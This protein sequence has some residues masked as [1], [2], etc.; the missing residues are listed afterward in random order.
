MRPKRRVRFALPLSLLLVACSSK[1]KPEPVSPLVADLVDYRAGLSMLKEGRA[2]EALQLLR[3]ARSVNPQDANVPNAIG[4]VFLYKKD[5]QAAIDAFDEA[6]KLDP[7][8]AEAFN[9]RGVTLM[10]A[11]RLD[12]AEKDFRAVLDGPAS[13]EKPNA[14]L[15]MGLVFGRRGK[16]PEAEQQFTL[17]IADAPGNLKAFRERGVARLNMEDFSG[18]LEDFLKVLKDEPRDAVSNYNA[19]LCL[20]T[21]GR[22]DLAVRYMQRAVSADPESEEGRKAS[23]FLDNEQRAQRERNP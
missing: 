14:R 17:A 9:N 6:L 4:L 7:R 10:E 11:G 18:A 15:N 13:P 21:Q 8:F 2:D 22:R 16:W 5:Y 12:E 23:R 19:A 20:L 3:R 1:P